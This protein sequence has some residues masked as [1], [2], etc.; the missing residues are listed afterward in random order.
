MT[1]GLDEISTV[2][3]DDGGV[4]NDNRLRAPQWQRLVGEF[5][6]PR[7]GGTSESWAAANAA[8]FGHLL[9]GFLSGASTRFENHR[10]W[11][12]AY[13]EAWLVGMCSAAD[14][15]LPPAHHV[16]RIARDA[17][18][19]ITRRVSSA[20]PGSA[21]AVR[22][23]RG[24]DLLL[25]MGSGGDSR[26]L[27][28]YLER[29]GIRECF[30]TLYGA[31]LVDMPKDR[32]E[33]HRRVLEDSGVDPARALFIDD[34]PAPLEWAASFGAKT[35]LIAPDPEDRFT[36]TAPSLAALVDRLLA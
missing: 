24:R 6:A 4:L 1:S 8:V 14:V 28:N 35:A 26:Q 16:Q 22:T 13:Y 11:I 27:A 12:E 32:P 3:I 23:L 9:Q 34:S 19:Y 30:H 15:P 10:D 31:D 18:D 29:M 2:F 20:I 33:Y 5:L 36:V 7:L 21:D 25:H 17:D